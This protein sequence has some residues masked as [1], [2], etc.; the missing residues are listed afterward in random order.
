MPMREG[1]FTEAAVVGATFAA[2]G[3]GIKLLYRAT[4]LEEDG[5]VEKKQVPL[6]VFLFATGFTGHL[7]WEATGGNRKFAANFAATLPPENRAEF[8]LELR[9]ALIARSLE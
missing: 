6:P 4:G 1:L 5:P 8:G 7:L 3:L 2:L 9:K